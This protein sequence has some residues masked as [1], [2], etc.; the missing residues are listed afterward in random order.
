MQVSKHHKK[1][2]LTWKVYQ[3]AKGDYTSAFD[4]E[5]GLKT[6]VFYIDLASKH[7]HEKMNEETRARVSRV[8]PPALERTL[9][10]MTPRSPHTLPP[11]GLLNFVSP[12][13]GG[14]LGGNQTLAP[15]FTLPVIAQTLFVMSPGA[16][17]AL[18]PGGPTNF[19][20]PYVAGQP[21]GNLDIASL[22]PQVIW[23]MPPSPQ[24]LGAP[25]YQDVHPMAGL[26]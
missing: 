19:S 23:T 11:G 22:M 12:T 17:H 7:L 3:I 15:G 8:T 16:A 13:V 21:G 10:T 14:Q 5:K 9:F 4:L 26:N 18:T 2:D 24:F 1:V 6:E 25:Q 20:T